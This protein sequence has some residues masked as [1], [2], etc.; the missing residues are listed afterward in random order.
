MTS[1]LRKMGISVLGDIPWGTHFCQFYQTKED[2]LDIL[3][4]YF[5][6]GLENN[7]FCLW[8]V[9]EPLG[10]DEATAALRRAVPEADRHLT[11]GSMKIV[12]HPFSRGPSR[13][14][15]TADSIEIVP[16]AKWYLKDGVF[17]AE[18]VIDGWRE[19]LDDALATG[20]AGMRAN[21][22]EAWLTKEN[23]EEFGRYEKA[24]DLALD[25]KRM[26]VLCSY[27]LADAGAAEM[28]DVVRTHQF[29]VV[30][31]NRDWEVVETPELKEAKAEIKRLNE[32]LERRV[33]ER[34]RELQA[35]NE[36]LGEEIVERKQ[37]EEQLRRAE[38]QA[39]KV[40]DTIP[41]Q[42]W[43]GP[44]DGT[45]DYCNYQWR[46]YAGLGL[47]E[48]QGD[49][50]QRVLHPDDKDRVLKAWYESVAT[51]VP[52][53]QEE[54]HRRF[55]G[56]YRWFL[57]RGVPLRDAEGHIERWYGANTDI[58]ERKRAE[59]RLGRSNEELR[60]LS[61]RL[62]SVREEE[63]ARIAREIHDELGAELSSLKWDLEEVG[64][65]I[66]EP[67]D[68]S[69]L[70]ALR[71]KVG[72]M[73]R[74]I[75]GAVDTVRRISS[76]LRPTA[77]EEFGLAEALGWYAQQFEA[78]TGIAVHCDC[79]PE[80]GD[81]NREQ[82]VAVFRIFQEALTNVLRHAQATRVDIRMRQEDAHLD[83]TISDNGRGITEDEKGGSQSLGLLGM[84]ERTHLLGGE[85]SI[86][87]GE[88][89]GTTITVR[90][91]TPAQKLVRGSRSNWG[92]GS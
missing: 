52:Y 30:R 87:G 43:S 20:Y 18:Q 66:S 54:R 5:K 1:E 92:G 65:I 11:A 82:S 71:E 14:A 27:P 63:S 74:L 36:K 75:D 25:G 29:A 59:E 23:W 34:T 28:L 44:P 35:A 62:H 68:Q 13:Q 84:R 76:E 57:C 26:I 24:L 77:L 7:E 33:V 70:A 83:L 41:Q 31:R 86:E 10:L 80:D 73:I 42:I 51:G 16:H 67:A 58:T 50:W 46:A 88:G 78:R 40:L 39:R 6:A 37:A 61:A 91:P 85:I 55:D 60:A 64:E 21:G 32:E 38:E 2:L 4:P 69:R 49:G 89:R 47:E 19:K 48:L 53:E 12:P 56:V 8:L 9:S 79:Q 81:L 90:V 17:N 3:L 15:P 22:N 45:L 72:A